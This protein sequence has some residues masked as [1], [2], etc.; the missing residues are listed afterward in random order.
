M[1]HRD[2]PTR[3]RRTEAADGRLNG[4]ADVRE[5]G[6]VVGQ[7]NG[8]DLYKGRMLRAAPRA[9]VERDS[10]Q[11]NLELLKAQTKE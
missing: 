2:V 3:L 9:R 10:F 1:V 6:R 7:E 4:G 11:R 8:G 5:L